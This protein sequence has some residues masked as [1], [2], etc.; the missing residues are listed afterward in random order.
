M[1]E[2]RLLA[3]SAVWR[4]DGDTFDSKGEQWRLVIN[5]YISR[6]RIIT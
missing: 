6:V 3:I 5:G 1:E 2:A 4:G